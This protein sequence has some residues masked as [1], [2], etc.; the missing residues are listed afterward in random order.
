MRLSRLRLRL[1]AGFAIAFLAGLGVLNTLLFLFVVHTGSQ[2]FDVQLRAAAAAARTTLTR[3][4]GALQIRG[5]IAGV[6][7]DAL[8]DWSPAGTAYVVYDARGHEVAADG[9]PPMI[10]ALRGGRS[11]PP[12]GTV[13]SRDMPSGLRFRYAVDTAFGAHLV[14]AASTDGLERER[15]HVLWRMAIS[16]PLALLIA[17]TI[18]YLLSRFALA[19]IR[20]L[21]AATA[22]IAPGA[23]TGRLPV[24]A[25]PDELDR[26]ARQFNELLD[27]IATLQDQ[28]QHFLRQA[29]HQIRTPLTLV[30]GESELSLERE[31]TPAEYRDI[32]RRV[33]AAAGQMQ[34]RVRDLFLLARMEAGE[35]PALRDAVEL[36][37]LAFEATDLFRARARTLGARLELDRLEPV[38]VM[39]DAVLLR[40]A[41]LELL[42]NACRHGDTSVPVRVRVAG[43]GPDAVLEVANAGP[44]IEPPARRGDGRRSGPAE[45]GLGLAIVAWIAEVHAGILDLRREADANRVALRLPR[46]AV[47]AAGAGDAGP[48]RS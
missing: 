34:H 45:N 23:L 37:A 33:H 42:E 47:S 21:G 4:R 13:A 46:A 29:A 8:S 41:L 27:R 2:G 40:E 19:P 16:V 39:G 26:L 20:A 22:A 10:E 17:L 36:D 11:L 3:T 32:L 31:R 15:Q 43:D 5:D 38:T 12:V 30:L 14:V 18:G 6:M 44:P 48:D 25:T 1:T 7:D 24:R 28:S 35:R 9:S